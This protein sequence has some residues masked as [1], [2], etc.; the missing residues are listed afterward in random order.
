[1]RAAAVDPGLLA[2]EL[3]ESGLIPRADESADTLGAL[4]ELGVRLMI[5]DFGTGYSSLSY[6]QRFP[7]TALKIARE[8]VAH[9]G[10]GWGLAAAIIAMAGTLGLDVVAEGIE[11][12]EQLRRLRDLGCSKAQGYLLARPAPAAELVASA[13]IAPPPDPAQAASPVAVPA[14][15]RHEPG[16]VQ[17]SATPA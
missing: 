11:T 1:L 12:P 17:E 6:L 13:R 5:D 10:G 8:F 9:D 14:A 7:V 4:R 3:T 15:R 16:L 2:L